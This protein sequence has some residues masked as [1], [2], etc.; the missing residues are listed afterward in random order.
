MKKI[1]LVCNA[2]LDL[3]WQWEW[4]EGL[5]EALS[6]FRIA[7]DFCE[8][9][10]GFVF[11][12]NESI[13]YQW[14]EEY[15]PELFTRIQRLV[16]MGRWHIMGGWYLQPDC[17]MPSGESMVRQISAG[18]TYFMEKFG[19]SPTTAV[20]FD[21]FGHSRGLVQILRRAG[22]D[23]YIVGR[24]DPG[25]FHPPARDFLWVGYDGSE[26][27]THISYQ[28]YN[29][30]LGRATE[31][32]EAFCRENPEKEL[33][34]VLWGI[35]NHG[36]GP[37][38]IDLERI[39]ELQQRYAQ[40]G[41]CM[42]HTTPEAYFS[43]IEK[44]ALPRF[45]EPLNPMMVG[46]YTSQVQ[47]K[48]K[49]RQLENELF[50]TEKMVSVAQWQT[51]RQGNW[52]AIRQAEQALLFSQFHDVL[53]GSTVK[54]AEEA[55]LRNLNYGLE[56][57]NRERMKAFMTLAANVRVEKQ[58]GDIPILI[59]NAHPYPVRR[60]VACEF[61]LQDQNRSGTHTDFEVYQAGQRIPAQLEKEDSTIPIDWRKKILFEA[62]LAPFAI[63]AVLC[64]PVIRPKKPQIFQPEGE[65]ILLCGGKTELRISKKTGWILEFT[66]EGK[67]LLCPN[68]G[69]LLVIQGSEDPWGMTVSAYRRVVGAFCLA[70]PERAG[71]I[72]GLQHS[73]APVRIIEQG[74]VRTVVEAI[75]IYGHSAAIVHYG[76]EH[77]SGRLELNVTLQWMEPDKMVKLSLQS[78]FRE[79]R[80][81][82]QDL[83]GR[84]QTSTDGKETI[85][86][87]WV[88]LAGEERA[89]AVVN[90][91]TYGHDFNGKELRVSLL[92]APAYCAHPVDDRVV[93]PQDRYLPRIDIGERSF[94]LILLA[95]ERQNMLDTIDAIAQQ[96]NELPF[97]LSF[98]PYGKEMPAAAGIK[99]D[100]RSVIISAI[101]RRRDDPLIRLFNPTERQQKAN[102]DIL[103]VGVAQMLEFSA[104]EV[105]TLCL[106]DGKLTPVLL[107][108]SDICE[109]GKGKIENA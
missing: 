49:H 8:Q 84:K 78:A 100:N 105:K 21:A 35:G 41:I 29:S 37:S 99:M 34:L 17:N 22:Y 45:S 64:R 58:E 83:F 102:L 94:R 62:E 31:K 59:F 42:E 107:D 71:Q 91:G 108:G 5:A 85:N 26:V 24:P 74:D 57:L 60:M 55:S 70:N 25:L 68:S 10:D 72:A 9:Y 51:G 65:E 80:C 11:N 96:E 81:F 77:S 87:Q 106:R 30:F 54:R 20:N 43:Q 7:A 46:C 79:S 39:A 53:P 90:T 104:Y 66:Q 88:V 23:S 103:A 1:C 56:L 98:F 75:F 13:L 27:A 82:A 109:L 52:E 38:R 18:R 32:I 47:V 86:Q 76:L 2:H 92:H 67:P 15:E 89:L 73:L 40:Q 69:K 33:L 14:V 3:V 61:Q 93:L 28:L 12:H 6:T 4:E 19:K 97:A 44:A 101:T 95:G 16:G 63:T 50:S 36:G 48:Q